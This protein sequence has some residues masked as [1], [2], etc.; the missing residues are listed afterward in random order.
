MKTIKTKANLP[1]EKT[2]FSAVYLKGKIYTFGGYDSYLKVQLQGCEYYDIKQDKW[3]NSPIPSNGHVPEYKL[4]Q[5]RSQSSCCVFED[6]VIYVFGGYHRELGTLNS[7][8]KLD[9]TKK[10]MVK[11]DIVIPSPI[12]RFASL[13]ISTTKILL[14]GGLGAQS[15]EL[16]SVF[17]FDLEKDPTIEQLDKIEKAGIVDCPVLLDQVGNLHLF[18]ENNSGTSPHNHVIY[19]FLEYS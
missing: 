4:H 9:L 2:F 13:K 7:I 10:K 15:E 1:H 3:H 5:E 6:D 12:R 11:L 16:D 18:L 17:C 8:E 19:S 14:I